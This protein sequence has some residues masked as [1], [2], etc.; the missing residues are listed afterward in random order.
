[1][2]VDNEDGKSLT[3]I[4]AST[5]DVARTYPLGFITNQTAGTLSIVDEASHTVRKPPVR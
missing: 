2:Y 1:M 5:L 3:G 4:D